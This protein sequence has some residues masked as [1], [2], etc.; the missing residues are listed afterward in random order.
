[1]KHLPDIYKN[2]EKD[3]DS[4]KGFKYLITK[5]EEDGVP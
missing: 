5:F 1:M 2:F 4:E 3:E